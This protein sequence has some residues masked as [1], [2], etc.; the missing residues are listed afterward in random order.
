MRKNF[1]RKVNRGE[2][3]QQHAFHPKSDTATNSVD[4]DSSGIPLSSV[5]EEIQPFTGDYL[6]WIP[7][8]CCVSPLPPPLVRQEISVKHWKVDNKSPAE[9]KVLE[10]LIVTDILNE[11]GKYEL[12]SISYIVY[13]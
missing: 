3:Q 13:H 7:K 6:M 11:E 4:Y 9:E 5:S 12:S 8:N 2:R 1:G 10:F